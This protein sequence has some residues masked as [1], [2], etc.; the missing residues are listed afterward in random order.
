MLKTQ[1]PKSSLSPGG[2]FGSVFSAAVVKPPKQKQRF[3]RSA[4]LSIPQI[5]A[6]LHTHLRDLLGIGDETFVYGRGEVTPGKS[7]PYQSHFLLCPPFS[8][9][10]EVSVADHAAQSARNSRSPIWAYI[11]DWKPTVGTETLKKLLAR[12]LDDL[13]SEFITWSYAG[14]YRQDLHQH[15]DFWIEHI[16]C[17]ITRDV[18]L[19]IDDQ[20]MENHFDKTELKKWMNIATARLGALRVD[21]LFEIV[22]DWGS[23]EP[24]IEDL[25]HFTTNPTTRSYLTSNFSNV[26][27]ARLL[28]PGASTL[29]ILQVYISIIRSF[30][31]LDLKGVLLDRVAR[32]VRRYLRDRDDTV[33]VILTGLLSD[34]AGEN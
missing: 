13:L 7:A 9:I 21:E 3:T 6:S 27:Q 23:T 20:L 2:V 1:A 25:R 11:K 12:V 8:E 17:A 22:V 18:L 31:L 32:K 28:H 5:Q 4:A 33:K 14:V 34:V 16:F 26:L 29:E 30:R 10:R 15:L 24:A 19:A